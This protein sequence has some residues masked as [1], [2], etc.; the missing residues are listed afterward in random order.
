M[1]IQPISNRQMK[2]KTKNQHHANIP[3]IT[4][5]L[6]QSYTDRKCG[7]WKLQQKYTVFKTT[8]K[9]HLQENVSNAS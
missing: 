7:S 4:V 5:V 6:Y 8:T 3:K 1:T 2:L 9:I